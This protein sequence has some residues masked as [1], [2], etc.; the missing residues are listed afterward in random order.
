MSQ[1]DGYASASEGYFSAAESVSSLRSGRSFGF[2][3]AH[4]GLSA[5][6]RRASGPD[7]DSDDEVTSRISHLMHGIRT[8]GR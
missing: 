2:S 7:S 3:G 6:G 1:P 4:P 5:A 8:R